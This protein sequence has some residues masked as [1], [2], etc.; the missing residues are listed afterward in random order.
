M[1][2][3]SGGSS[4]ELE[5]YTSI[6]SDYHPVPFLSKPFHQSN[7]VSNAQDDTPTKAYLNTRVIE[8]LQ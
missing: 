3:I 4:T 7:V 2:S 6:S 8:L 1:D 5:E